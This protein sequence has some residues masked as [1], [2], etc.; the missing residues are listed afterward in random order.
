MTCKFLNS[1]YQPRKCGDYTS[2]YFKLSICLDSHATFGDIFFHPCVCRDIC[3]NSYSKVSFRCTLQSYNLIFLFYLN[4][5]LHTCSH[6]FDMIGNVQIHKAKMHNFY[7]S[8]AWCIKCSRKINRITQM[9][10]KSR[11]ES[12]EPNQDVIRH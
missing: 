3:T 9:G 10:C 2:S 6:I 1:Q 11:N 8:L 4:L 7:K 12:N 5:I